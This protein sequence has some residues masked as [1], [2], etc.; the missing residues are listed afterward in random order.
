MAY[1]TSLPLHQT[2]VEIAAKK[3]KGWRSAKRKTKRQCKFRKNNPGC[4][5]K[6]R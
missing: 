6:R 1:R 2:E 5:Q 3:P 4:G